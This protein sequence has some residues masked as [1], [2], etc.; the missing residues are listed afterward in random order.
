MKVLGIDEAGR[1]CVIGPMAIGAVVF[2]EST[3]GCLEKLGVKD[4]KDLSPK[5]REELFPRIKE[6]A[7]SFEVKLIS[8]AD[9]DEFSLNQIDLQ[10]IIFFITSFKPD[11]VIIDVPAN[12]DGVA[13]FVK[14]VRLGLGEFVNKKLPHSQAPGA[15]A[16]L[17]AGKAGLAPG[18]FSV[19]G[20]LPELIGENKADEK[21][22]IVSAASILA[23]V[24]RDRAIGALHKEYG[25]FGS[26]Y[27]SDEQT[28]KFLR[29]WFKNN[30][31]FPPIVRSKWSSVKSFFEKQQ[32]LI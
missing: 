14:A 20:S 22:P 6:K 32:G 19:A 29:E 21:Y 3:L 2:E 31:D 24:E 13:N 25:D 26:G 15:Y 18:A 16:D 10:Q 11:K 28:Q 17:P 5:K 30:R 8:P 12:P 23:K 27:M 4:S 1:G 7:N 9:I